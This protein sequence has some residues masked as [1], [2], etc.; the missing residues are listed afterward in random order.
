MVQ[1]P[2][3]LGSR[4]RCCDRNE[5]WCG[6]GPG[7]AGGESKSGGAVAAGAAWPSVVGEAGPALAADAAVR[8]GWVTEVRVFPTVGVTEPAVVVT[9]PPAVW[10][11]WATVCSAV[12]VTVVLVEETWVVTALVAPDT[13]VVAV[14]VACE[15]VLV[16]V[17][18]AL[19]TAVGA[20]AVAAAGAVLVC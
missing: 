5:A 16:T 1:P 12:E 7:R 6:P 4:R 20:A 2:P 3:R 10:T 18:A 17:F 13:L 9:R 19:V 11:V 15:A 8:T 14:W